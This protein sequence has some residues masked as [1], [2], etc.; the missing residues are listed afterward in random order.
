MENQLNSN[1]SAMDSGTTPAVDLRALEV[2]IA[3]RRA[4]AVISEP[5]AI[6]R[7]SPPAREPV[8][9]E[10]EAEIARREQER[11]KRE[12]LDKLAANRDIL[13]KAVGPRY[14]KCSLDSYQCESDLQHRVVNALRE[15][16]ESGS[17]DLGEGIVLYGPVGTG[18]D[19]L[20]HAVAAECVGCDFR[21]QW[22]NG[23]DLFGEIRDRMDTTASESS[24]LANYT[25][26]QLLVIS[27]PLPPFGNL[28]Q[29][30][31]TMLYRL[32]DDRA[33]RRL[34]TFVSINVADDNEADS[35]LGAATWDRMCDGVWKMH[36][37]WPSHRKPVKEIR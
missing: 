10:R 28:S 4:A 31:A 19:H 16:L 32:M 36:C 6:K 22:V 37:N 12:R 3:E 14:A 26:A 33:A 35:R 23:Q 34:P 13:R 8:S 15:Y 17:I 27:D 7:V 9:P 30:Q 11:E 25:T 2:L 29:H 20:L 21:V 1:G 24:L 5:P 18:K